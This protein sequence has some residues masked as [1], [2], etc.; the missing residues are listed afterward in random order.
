MKR[1][2]KENILLVL[3]GTAVILLLAM[4]ANVGHAAEPLTWQSPCANNA[5]P[6]FKIVKPDKLEM[7]CLPTDKPFMTIQGCVGPKAKK[8]M[9]A[10]KPNVQITCTSWNQY[11]TNIPMDWTCTPPPAK[12]QGPLQ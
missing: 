10:G 12:V 6:I 7:R 9:V 1:S 11:Q 8:V 2:T 5:V 4:F 3:C